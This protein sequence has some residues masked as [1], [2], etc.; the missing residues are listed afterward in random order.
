MARISSLIAAAYLLMLALPCV[1]AAVFV[2][3]VNTSLVC[4]VQNASLW[5]AIPNDNEVGDY[6]YAPRNNTGSW[7]GRPPYLEFDTRV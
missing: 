6:V 7:G 4:V 5:H 3:T 2:T 1:L